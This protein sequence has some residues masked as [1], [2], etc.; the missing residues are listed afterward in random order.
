MKE[1]KEEEL[2]FLKPVP[3]RTHRVLFK[4]A[5]KAAEQ[6]S[7]PILNG[8]RIYALL[9]G[10]FIFG[11][12][13]E[14]FLVHNNLLA[15]EVT[16]SS[17][18]I[19]NEN[20]CSL[21]ALIAKDY[22]RKL[23]LLVSDH[24]YAN[25]RQNIKYIYDMLD[26]ADVF[27]FAV[28]SAHTKTVL[29]ETESGQKIVIHGSANLKSNDCVEQICIESDP[30]VYDFFYKYQKGIFKQYSI[31]NKSARGLKMWNLL[32]KHMASDMPKRKE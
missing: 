21:S 31:C 7:K 13:I 23:N 28:G 4:Y 10:R 9:S 27:D 17:L 29:I 18:S 16:I 6:L 3:I 8:D 1:K 20:I 15:R 22:I 14:A 5:K 26:I 25:N 19:S 12:F 32:E 24:F 11:D 2:L 30:K